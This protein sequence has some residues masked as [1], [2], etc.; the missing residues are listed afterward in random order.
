MS[1]LGMRKQVLESANAFAV[2]LTLRSAHI[3]PDRLGDELITK[4]TS[5]LWALA[6]N[7]IDAL[8]QDYTSMNSANTTIGG[9]ANG[10]L[11]PQ[12]WLNSIY[13]GARGPDW[14]WSNDEQPPNQPPMGLAIEIQFGDAQ[15]IRQLLADRS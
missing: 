6:D 5:G 9:S 10:F 15:R 2:T 3:P 1:N 7:I 8:H 14:F 12:T 13:L 11:E 4:A